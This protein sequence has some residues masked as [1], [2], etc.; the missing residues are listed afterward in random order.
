[1]ARRIKGAIRMS[2]LTRLIDPAEGEEKLPVHQF[3]AGLAEY[4]RGAIT[5]P[6]LVEAFNL[7]GAEAT[8][9]Q[10]FLDNLDGDAIDRALIHDVLLL[11]ETGLYSAAQ[12]VS[13]LGV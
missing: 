13:R 9:L 8:Q 6:Q 5:G 2:L 3:M 4:K 1:M 10:N 7:S 12:V 11:G